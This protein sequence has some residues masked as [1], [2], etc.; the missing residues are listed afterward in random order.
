MLLFFCIV[1][2][3]IDVCI[4][5][6]ILQALYVF[7]NT[8]KV[9]LRVQVKKI[10]SSKWRGCRDGFKHQK[11]RNKGSLHSKVAQNYITPSLYLFPFL[12]WK[13]GTKHRYDD[14]HMLSAS[15]QHPLC[16][17]HC[18]VSSKWHL[19]I[20]CLLWKSDRSTIVTC[21]KIAWWPCTPPLNMEMFS[22]K[23][24]CFCLVYWTKRWC[25]W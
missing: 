22:E 25:W 15:G 9:V 6:C 5:L 14:S 18:W 2:H 24:H 10:I 13:I 17:L 11:E 8:C 3:V 4:I 7:L 1:R 12:L 16:M 21:N 23:N 19:V 20:Q